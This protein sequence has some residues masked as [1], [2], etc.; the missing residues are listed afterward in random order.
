MVLAVMAAMVLAV[1]AAM[2]LA[3][4]VV[5]VVMDLERKSGCGEVQILKSHLSDLVASVCMRSF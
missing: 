3:V 4:M 2:V 5:M 1:M